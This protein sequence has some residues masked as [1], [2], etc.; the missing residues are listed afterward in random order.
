MVD[1]SKRVGLCHGQCHCYTYRI[2][3]GGKL[4][5]V[6]FSLFGFIFFD[7]VYIMAIMNY[8]IQSELNIYLLHALRIKVER[9]EH[10]SIDAAIKV[11]NYSNRIAHVIYSFMP[12]GH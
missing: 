1:H 5:L 11:G 12:T 8:A 3:S 9:R 4:T 6:I 10:K 2:K 7:A